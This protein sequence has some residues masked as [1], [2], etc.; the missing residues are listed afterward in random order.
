MTRDEREGAAKRKKREGRNDKQ[1]SRKGRNG[2]GKVSLGERREKRGQ[3][4]Q[5]GRTGKGE[6]RGKEI[7]ENGGEEEKL[8]ERSK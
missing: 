8:D 1:M 2:D 6:E 3:R 5:K 7:E 4:L